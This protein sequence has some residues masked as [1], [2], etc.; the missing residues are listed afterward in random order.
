MGHLFI[1]FYQN[2][3]EIWWNFPWA[4]CLSVL[5]SRSPIQLTPYIACWQVT[6]LTRVKN[7]NKSKF[8]WHSCVYYSCTILIILSLFICTLPRPNPFDGKS[9]ESSSSVWSVKSVNRQINCK[10]HWDGD[11]ERGIYPWHFFKTYEITEKLSINFLLFRI[12]K[13]F[14]LLLHS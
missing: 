7:T 13:V 12:V 3:T 14:F 6:Y 10:N 8:L 2:V 9:S 1:V 11:R 4:R 5:Y